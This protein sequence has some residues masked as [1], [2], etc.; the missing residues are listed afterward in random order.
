MFIQSTFTGCNDYA[1]VDNLFLKKPSLQRLR[2]MLPKRTKYQVLAIV[3][4]LLI[5]PSSG[6][7]NGANQSRTKTT[8]EMTARGTV[9]DWKDWVVSAVFA[10]DNRTIAGGSYDVVKLVDVE[11][12][13][14]LSTIKTNLGYARSLAFSPDGKTLAAGCYQAVLLIEDSGKKRRTLKKH[15][16]QVTGVCFSHDGKH[17]VTGS[18]DETVRI[19]DWRAGTCLQ[20]IDNFV[21]P[22]Q[23]VELSMDGQLIA[24]ATGDPDRPTKQGNVHLLNLDGKP[25]HS[26]EGHLKAATDVVFTEDAKHLLSSSTD[27]TANVYEIATGKALGF[28]GGHVRQINAIDTRNGY[29]VTVS[30][31]GARGKNEL[32]IWKLADGEE[33]LKLEPHDSKITD[34]TISPNGRMIATTSEDKTLALWNTPDVLCQADPTV[35]DQTKKLRVGII[36]LDTSHVVAFTG[37]LNS[38]TPEEEL[39]NCRVV[40]A[41][42]QGSPDIQSSVERVPKYTDAVKEKGVKIVASI[43]DLLQQVDCVLLETNDGRPH[44]EQIL[45]CLKAGKPVFVD[46]P[47]AGSLS[48]AIAIF[49]A[50]RHFKVPVFSSSS[51]RFSKGAQEI[52]GGKFGKVIGADTYS[53]CSMESTHPDLFWYGIHGVEALF[54]VMGSGCESV[55][56]SSNPAHELVVGTWNGV[57][58][59]TFR[60]I[61]NGKTGYGGTVFTDTG[62]H[63]IGGYDGYKPLL[64]EIVRFF[65][66]GKTPIA[67]T[68]TLEIYAFMEAADESKRL[69]GQPVR[70]ED[71][72]TKAREVAIEKLKTMGVELP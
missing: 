3:T 35:P 14:V 7:G 44:L 53:P 57:G 20:T 17:L 18:D 19:W 5:L 37:M 11:S 36:G 27:Q 68:E 45:P 21:L 38:E 64:I 30:G 10:P 58:T 47:M 66:T 46:K 60:G 29:G 69:G 2:L 42:P 72:M 22:V 4:A 1:G 55:V 40:A 39:R 49:E 63:P 23:S 15:R 8:A 31:G 24:V 26:L 54:T 62:I 43:D 48:D 12:L 6:W 67:E 61:K 41:Y 65:H 32:R 16:G 25:A 51:L 59:G 28:F 33:L 56:R 50:A 9:T 71:V 52:R 70:L 34:V 13:Q